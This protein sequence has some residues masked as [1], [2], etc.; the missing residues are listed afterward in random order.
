MVEG[1]CE[2]DGLRAST[3]VLRANFDVRRVKFGEFLGWRIL[4]KFGKKILCV[5]ILFGKISTCVFVQ[6]SMG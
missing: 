2:G 5:Y 3:R 1:C 6:F 4:E